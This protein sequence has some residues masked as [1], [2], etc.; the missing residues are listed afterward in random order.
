M[1]IA[2]S[3]LP[4]KTVPLAIVAS[5]LNYIAIHVYDQLAAVMNPSH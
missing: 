5:Y 2:T 1:K 3:V 4:A